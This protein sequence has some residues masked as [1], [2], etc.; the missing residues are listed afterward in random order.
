MLP[1]DVL[2]EVFFYFTI[3]EISTFFTVNTQFNIDINWKRFTQREFGIKSQYCDTWKDTAK[4]LVQSNMI[5]LSKEWI[6]GKT[7]YDIFFESLNYSNY[8]NDLRVKYRVWEYCFP[9]HV[10]DSESVI[11]FVKSK[12]I[13]SD[14]FRHFQ[15]IDV[16]RERYIKLHLNF[17]TRVYILSTSQ[18]QSFMLCFIVSYLTINFVVCH[19]GSI[20]ISMWKP[21]IK[22]VLH[23]SPQV[24]KFYVGIMRQ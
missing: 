3:G 19:Y 13:T 7:Y 24:M 4:L 9:E 18:I 22:Y 23:L 12:C 5:N 14:S 16:D 10:I 8:F 15:D 6:N 20:L 2:E 21:L 1:K 17:N 11:K